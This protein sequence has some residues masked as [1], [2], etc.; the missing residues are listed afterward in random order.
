MC[1]RSWHSRRA[2]PAWGTASLFL[3]MSQVAAA[4][5]EEA[6]PPASDPP[7]ETTVAEPD[8]AGMQDESETGQTKKPSASN[9]AFD[10]PPAEGDAGTAP[11][12]E[13]ADIAR[14][15]DK[16]RI[17]QTERGRYGRAL[18]EAL[19][20][21]GRAYSEAGEHVFAAN[22]FKQA[23]FVARANYGLYSK[24]QLTALKELIEANKALG[25]PQDVIDNYFLMYWIHKRQ[26][27]DQDLRL[28]PVIDEVSRAQA[29]ISLGDDQQ[30]DREAFMERRSILRDAVKIV[31][32]NYGPEDPRV[33]GVL[34]RVAWANFAL[35]RQTGKL[36]HYREYR[37]SK[38]GGTIFIDE[39]LAER[40]TLIDEAVRRG[41]DALDRI[42]DLFEA[43]YEK[44]P[45]AAAYSLA[46]ARLHKGDWELLYGSG[47]GRREYADAYELLLESEEGEAAANRLLGDPQLLP[48]P[49]DFPGQKGLEEDAESPP[50]DPTRTIK[51]SMEIAFTGRVRNAEIVLA[52]DALQEEAE[53]LLQY[54]KLQRFRPRVEDGR[55]VTA[56]I[57]RQYYV[58]EDGTVILLDRVR[59]RDNA[60]TAVYDSSRRE[61][62]PASS[63]RGG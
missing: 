21:L 17:L 5:P 53:N 45:K 12:L 47:T 25:K 63:G 14:L 8:A 31:E 51:L 60:Q 16:V 6:T 19:I 49:V 28:L 38:R 40:F 44:D 27:G 55:T 20:D 18:D 42:E 29:G 15:L 48:A 9:G 26:Y 36:L 57:L 35:A 3:V 13:S 10:T 59:R 43:L 24:A 23:L 37:A 61:P 54:M 41:G 32:A 30:M 2:I 39:S 46:L 7:A 58:K 50:D 1:C 56:D 34:N 11:V 4:Q 22:A 62:E 52:P 33:A